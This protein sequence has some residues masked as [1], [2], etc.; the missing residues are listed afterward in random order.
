LALALVFDLVMAFLRLATYR[1]HKRNRLHLWQT[2]DRLISP[3]AALRM[4]I[5]SLFPAVDRDFWRKKSELW[6]PGIVSVSLVYIIREY[7]TALMKIKGRA[8]RVRY[9]SA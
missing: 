6:G 2:A 4:R 9:N 8:F 3:F 5:S 7:S 1:W